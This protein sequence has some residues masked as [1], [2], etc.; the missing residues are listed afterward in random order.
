MIASKLKINKDKWLEK[1]SKGVIESL[2]N[3][4][5]LEFLTPQQIAKIDKI[6]ECHLDGVL[7]EISE[8]DL[9]VR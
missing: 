4:E 8:F 6:I 1:L 3:S 5:E 2:S 7:N 9:V